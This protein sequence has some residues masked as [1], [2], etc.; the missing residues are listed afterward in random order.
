M[1]TLQNRARTALHRTVAA[2]VAMTAAVAVASGVTATVAATT[3]PANAPKKAVPVLKTV[4]LTP[5]AISRSW[6]LLWWMQMQLQ[7]KVATAIHSQRQITRNAQV[8]RASNAS[9]ASV[10]AVT[11]MAATAVNE[12]KTA[13][14]VSSQSQPMLKPHRP[15]LHAC[16]TPPTQLQPLFRSKI[17]PPPRR[18]G[19][20]S[21]L[22]L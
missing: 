21:L 19:H 2:K 1:A 5:N 9:L 18:Y 6:L 11:V 3:E 20:R 10:A 8:S 16:Q 14:A 13:K 12:V 15:L 4:H 22:K 7:M 17:R